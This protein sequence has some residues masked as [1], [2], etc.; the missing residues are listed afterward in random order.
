MLVRHLLLSLNLL[1]CD[2]F[3]VFNVDV[4]SLHLFQQSSFHEELQTTK[5]EKI[6]LSR[7][8]LSSKQA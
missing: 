2:C 7:S 5:G 4:I 3:S 1:P 8:D 6:R